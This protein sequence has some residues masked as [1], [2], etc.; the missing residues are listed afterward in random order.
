MKRSIA[1][2]NKIRYPNFG[3]KFQVLS[4]YTGRRLFHDD[5]KIWLTLGSSL[6][7]PHEPKPYRCAFVPQNLII[8][9]DLCTFTKVPD[10]SQT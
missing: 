10:G 5:G 8:S 6:Y 9:G 2:F 4:S 3:F 7:N 1:E